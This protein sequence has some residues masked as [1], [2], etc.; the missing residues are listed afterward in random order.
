MWVALLLLLMSHLLCTCRAAQHTGAQHDNCACVPQGRPDTF[1]AQTP[2][3]S[4]WVGGWGGGGGLGWG[5]E[6]G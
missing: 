2:L 6:E 3:V 5:V 4:M 1:L